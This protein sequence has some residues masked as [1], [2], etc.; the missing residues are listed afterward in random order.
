[1]TPQE[2]DEVLGRP[3][4]IL[5][6]PEDATA[7]RPERDLA[8]VRETGRC[9]GQS[10]DLRKDGSRCVADVTVT[11]L[12]DESGRVRGSAKVTRAISEQ[13]AAEDGANIVRKM[14]ARSLSERVRMA[15]LAAPNGPNGQ[16]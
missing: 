3:F 4:S 10:V 6:P 1:M 8:R 9:Q 11:P 15:L 12:R 2:G 7:D 13:I 14:Q 16:F 5:S